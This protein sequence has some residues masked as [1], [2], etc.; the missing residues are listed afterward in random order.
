MI[1]FKERM[2]IDGIPGILTITQNSIKF[3]WF[4]FHSHTKTRE[5]KINF[6]NISELTQGFIELSHLKFWGGEPI[7]NE[8]EFTSKENFQKI[9]LQISNSYPSNC[10][11]CFEN[12]KDYKTICGHSIC[13]QCFYKS[14]KFMNDPTKRFEFTCGI[15]RK[16]IFTPLIPKS[17]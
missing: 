11:V 3:S 6:S 8:M 14:I 5:W 12:A 1:L 4:D 17:N 10:Y 9:R 13:F 15:C 7:C 16:M 2:S